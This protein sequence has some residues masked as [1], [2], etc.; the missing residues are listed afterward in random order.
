MAI[1]TP[2]QLPRRER[3]GR[4][5]LELADAAGDPVSE[6]EAR[7]LLFSTALQLGDGTAVREHVRALRTLVDRVGD[8]GRRWSALYA[9]AALAHLEDDLTLAEQLNDDALTTF[10]PVSASRAF[11]AYGGQLLALRL[12]QGRLAE[13]VESLE[14]LTRDQPGVPAWRA[15]VSLALADSD[16]ARAARSAELALDAP[17]EDFFWLASRLIAGRT[18]ALVGDRPLAAAYLAQ[19]APWTGLACW[20]G[21]CSYGPVD[22]TLALLHRR[23]G[24]E[25]AT[26]HHAAVARDLAQRLGAPVF[27]RDLDSLGL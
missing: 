5:L 15:A 12:A 10:A 8:I 18:A 17:P 2:D 27:L 16:P 11:A 3:L 20:Q 7:H 9:S 6:F 23:L 19:L 26:R 13:L 14:E 1:G 4:E 21:T 22:T 25:T 24:D